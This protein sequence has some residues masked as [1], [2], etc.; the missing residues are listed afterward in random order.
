MDPGL[1]AKMHKAIAVIQFKVEGQI[2]RRHPGYLMDDRILLEAVDYKNGTVTIQGK[3]YPLL[4][5]RFPTIDPRHPLKLTAEEEALLHTL[6]LSFK[7]S[8]LLHKHIKFLYSHGGMYK[9]YNGNLLYHGC[10]PMAQDGT[11]E[12]MIFDGEPCSGKSLMDHIDQRI[13][14]A[15]FLPEDTKEKEDAKDFMWY[16]WCG[17]K[18]PVFGK[19][20]MTTFEH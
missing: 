6:I 2:I 19:D 4:D 14:N 11:F 9:C 1:A 8:E 3:E 10:I 5:T 18:S 7:H 15:Y 20:K 12:K 16:L 13:Q 17:A